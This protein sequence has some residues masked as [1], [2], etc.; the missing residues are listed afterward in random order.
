MCKEHAQHY[1]SHPASGDSVRCCDLCFKQLVSKDTKDEINHHI[2]SLK[3]AIADTNTSILSNLQD[4]EAQAK[5]FLSKTAAL[6]Y[7]KSSLKD[8]M[9]PLLLRLNQQREDTQHTQAIHANLLSSLP[10]ALELLRKKQ[11]ECANV[12]ADYSEAMR[13]VE[14]LATDVKSL[15]RDVIY[16]TSELEAR[17]PLKELNWYI[18]GCCRPNLEHISVIGPAN[19]S[20]YRESLYDRKVQQSREIGKEKCKCEVS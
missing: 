4:S 13:E 11:V 14:T 19:I 17:V 3:A 10:H 18:G 16:W 20:K 7:L 6:T 8:H 12:S 2:A 15:K 1:R 5:A 9:Q